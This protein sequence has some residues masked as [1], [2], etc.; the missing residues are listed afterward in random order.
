MAIRRPTV[1][2]FGSLAAVA[3]AVALLPVPP[4]LA[5]SRAA[6]AW[7]TVTYRGVSLQ[8]PSAWPVFD[9][10]RDPTR[11]VRFDR[12]AVYLG[13]QGD[14]P[15]CPAGLIGRTE[16]LQVEPLDDRAVAGVTL[17][18]GR[19][20]VGGAPARLASGADASHT[21]AAALPSLG[22]MVSLPYGSDRTLVDRI[23][24]S[25]RQ[26]G[27]VTPR[28]VPDTPPPA[29]PDTADVSIRT[30]YTGQGFDACTAPS[31]TTMKAWTGS[32]F[33]SLG[34]YI[35]GA[36]RACSQ[37]N[38]T[39]SW[40]TSVEGMGWRLAPLWVGLQAPC[41]YHTGV[42][43]IDPTRPADQGVA[44]A[45]YAA[46]AASDLALGSHTPIYFD[47][48]GYSAN[49]TSCTKSVQSFVTGWV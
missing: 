6:A 12:H 49:N 21:L 16:A 17:S 1:A 38:L 4:A 19:T 41:T 34:T 39:T 28:P 7:R 14:Q 2:V 13:H 47:M 45:D 10:R 42:A 43:K 36:N 15:D 44:S 25:V 37:A 26:T 11:C 35:G 33:H 20:T 40:V 24:A 46:T 48:E 31:T 23:L 22:V 29:S 8:V 27:A 9:L 5:A 3:L 32:P 18:P 30:I